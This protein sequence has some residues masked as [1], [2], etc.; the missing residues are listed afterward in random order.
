MSKQYGLI[1]F[2]VATPYIDDRG[3]NRFFN[4][5]FV[6]PPDFTPANI[7]SIALQ[8]GGT[9]RLPTDPNTICPDDGVEPR[10]LQF[11]RLNGNS[12]S[13]P[14]A[15]RTSL[16]AQAIALRN[17]INSVNANN[18]VV[19]VK[20]IGEYFPNLIDELAPV[21][22]I[23]GVGIGSSAPANGKQVFYSGTMEYLSDGVFGSPYFVSFKVATEGANSTV[24]PALYAPQLNLANV[25]PLTIATCSGNNPRRSRRY[26]SQAIVNPPQGAGTASQVT[27]IPVATHLDTDI[28]AVGQGLAAIGAVQCLG[29]KGEN[30]DRFHR[31][32]P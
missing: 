30:N 12:I 26:I 6:A 11:I 8:S 19:C 3:T 5:N 29:Y 10:K 16:V 13:V 1:A 22:K 15:N 24:A 23:A 32:L 25:V 21:G 9:V 31:L 27:E 2:N 17:T 28:L 20:L 4:S 18:P 14:I 7:N